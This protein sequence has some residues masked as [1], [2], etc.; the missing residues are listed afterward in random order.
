LQAGAVLQEQAAKVQ[1][2]LVVAQVPDAAIK[3]S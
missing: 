1:L 3:K 2:L